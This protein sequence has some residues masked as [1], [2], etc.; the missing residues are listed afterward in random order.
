MIGVFDSGV[1]GLTVVKEIFRQLPDYPVVY[2][3]DTA[4]TPYGNKSKETIIRYATEDTDFLLSHGAQVIIIGCNTAS[5][6][7]AEELEEKYS[8]TPILEVISPAVKKA[9]SVTKNKKVGVI[10]TR[11][12]INS[13]VYE[14]KI[15]ELDPSIKVFSVACP[16]FVPLVEENWTDRPETKMIARRYLQGLKTKGIDTLILGCTHYP[17][18]KE[19]I[20]S[21]I[22]ARVA[23]VDSASEVVKELQE[24]LGNFDLK[25]GKAGK[26]FVSDLTPH[27][28]NIAQKL[29]GGKVELEET[30][31]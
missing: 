29:L 13:G 6:E 3:G 15:K 2:F 31:D 30:K 7:A 21:K 24:K 1:G 23:L 9:V 12:T 17:L 19:V 26:F 16:L 25:T 18:L 10:G 11:G 20:S 8:S 5:A 22:G 28:Q 14:R 27:I 4:R